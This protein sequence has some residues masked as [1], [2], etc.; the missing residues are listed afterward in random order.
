MQKMTS[1]IYINT[2]KNQIIIIKKKTFKSMKP[3]K[4]EILCQKELLDQQE[5]REVDKKI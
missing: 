5:K 2:M 4:T 3:R 1:I